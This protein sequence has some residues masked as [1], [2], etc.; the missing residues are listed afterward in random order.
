M[1]VRG[2]TVRLVVAV[3]ANIVRELR[4]HG[5]VVVS[6]TVSAGTMVIVLLRVALLIL[7]VWV[8]LTQQCW[9]RRWRWPSFLLLML[10]KDTAAVIRLRIGVC[11]YVG[12]L[13]RQHEVRR[14]ALPSLL[15]LRLLLRR[16]L[17]DGLRAGLYT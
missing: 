16:L 11:V 1:W 2:S 4:T 3:V 14:R 8:K 5:V 15:L 10:I 13:G 12:R 6:E 7:C 9:W 17:W